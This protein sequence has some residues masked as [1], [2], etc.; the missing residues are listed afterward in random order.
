MSTR[1]T[2][3]CV[4][5]VAALVGLNFS[6][7]KF[8]LEHS[9][10]IMLTAARSLVGGPVLLAFALLRGERPPRDRRDWGNIAVISFTIT[11][12]SSALLVIGTRRVPAGLASLLSS[13]MPLFTAVLGVM[14]LG[15][16]IT[17][18][19]AAG[20]AVGFVGTITL[21]IPAMGGGSQL[22][23][24]VVLVLSA[25][26]WAYG[27]VH[28]KWKEI[29]SVSPVMLVAIQLMMSAVVLL[30][31]GLLVEGT[32]E[33]DLGWGLFW[34][35]MYSAIPSQAFTFAL[36]A[37][38][39]RRASPTHAAA[40]AYLAPLFGVLF[41]WLLRDERLGALEVLGGALIVAG[42]YVVV[43]AASTPRLDAPEP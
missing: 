31:F 38:V 33:V 7:L 6:I 42:V 32:D 24:V 14:L 10:P 43:T 12:V 9:S 22:V 29:A 1:L 16:S 11:T 13:T 17:A 4:T 2:L 36:L 5:L 21:A 41:G 34:P 26:A 19:A 3:A 23:G 39:V 28:M 25:L 27:T 20:L 18:R 35:L 30:P 40:S 15:T 37:T 8:G